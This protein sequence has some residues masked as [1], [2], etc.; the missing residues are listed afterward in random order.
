MKLVLKYK[1][2][3]IGL[4]LGAIAGFTYW[5]L[6]GCESGTCSITSNPI[7]STL[8]GAFIGLLFLNSIKD[9]N[10]TKHGN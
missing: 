5:K 8:Y 1:F 3:L 2:T 10:Q 4:F 6:V 7:H 9:L